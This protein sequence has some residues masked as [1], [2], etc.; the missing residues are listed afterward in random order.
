MLHGFTDKVIAYLVAVNGGIKVQAKGHYPEVLP[1]NTPPLNLENGC[2]LAAGNIYSAP[3]FYSDF[4]NMLEGWMG[5]AAPT[6]QK[7]LNQLR[8]Q[9]YRCVHGKDLTYPLM[10][11]PANAPFPGSCIEG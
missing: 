4:G 6:D 10:N 1:S 9:G 11:R 5:P 7:D 8:A 2:S 3:F